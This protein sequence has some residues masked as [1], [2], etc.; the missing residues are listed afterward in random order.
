MDAAET[1]RAARRRAAWKEVIPGTDAR[2]G[3]V[4]R[5]VDD[6]LVHGGA[7]LLQQPL[8][9]VASGHLEPLHR[10]G[11]LVEVGAERVEERGGHA[12]VQAAAPV[13]L[14]P[15]TSSSLSTALAKGNR[16]VDRELQQR[17]VGVEARL[18][19]GNGR[20]RRRDELGE[21]FGVGVVGG[22]EAAKLALELLPVLLEVVAGC[23]RCCR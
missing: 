8:D 3:E 23:C 17:R 21:P 11:R 12:E 15:C 9:R 6:A 5:V 2:V 13:T 20:R 4:L 10:G 16:G 7:E 1:P 19:A 18:L 14:T 22:V